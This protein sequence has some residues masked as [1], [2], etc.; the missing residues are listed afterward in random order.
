MDITQVFYS[1]CT[2]LNFAYLKYVPYKLGLTLNQ[3]LLLLISSL[4][5]SHLSYELSQLHFVIL[6]L[7]DGLVRSFFLE[8]RIVEY[9]CNILLLSVYLS[10]Q[11][12]C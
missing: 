9:L 12:G 8:D 6:I 2:G 11:L 3:S 10:A 1:V 7:S 5:L 4:K